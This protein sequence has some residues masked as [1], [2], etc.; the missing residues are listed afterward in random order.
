M[1]QQLKPDG[2][3]TLIG[4]ANLANHGKLIKKFSR[5][6][7]FPGRGTDRFLENSSSIFSQF[8]FPGYELDQFLENASKIEHLVALRGVKQTDLWKIHPNMDEFYRNRSVSRPEKLKFRENFWMSFPGSA[9][10]RYENRNL[11]RLWVD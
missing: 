7:S 4:I 3:L 6:F 8:Q 1:L 2:L 10:K 5:N 9:N 11:L